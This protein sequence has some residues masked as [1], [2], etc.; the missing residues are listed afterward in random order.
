MLNDLDARKVTD[1]AEAVVGRA[2]ARSEEDDVNHLRRAHTSA[3][4]TGEAMPSPKLS[5]PSRP[6][7]SKNTIHF[8]GI[9][10]G[11]FHFCTCAGRHIE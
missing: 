2:V 8:T 4:P 11:I 10:T 6:H 7:V 5:T 3:I 1:L 9:F